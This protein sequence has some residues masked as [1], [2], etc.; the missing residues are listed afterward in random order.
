MNEEKSSERSMMDDATFNLIRQKTPTKQ[1][2]RR[3]AL[4]V[5]Q[6]LQ[7]TKNNKMIYFTRGDNPKEAD[8]GS[9]A[10]DVTDVIRHFFL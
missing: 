10:D 3:K 7:D 2:P 8:S 6:L 5:L 1:N 4:Q 9:G